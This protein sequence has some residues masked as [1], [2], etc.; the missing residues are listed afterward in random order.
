MNFSG[1][2]NELKSH[3]RVSKGVFPHVWY[4]SFYCKLTRVC[5]FSKIVY[6]SCILHFTQLMKAI[7]AGVKNKKFSHY[8]QIC[9]SSKFQGNVFKWNCL[10]CWPFANLHF[11][12]FAAAEKRT[13]LPVLCSGIWTKFSPVPTLYSLIVAT[14]LSFSFLLYNLKFDRLKWKT[15]LYV[16]TYMYINICGNAN[17]KSNGQ[18][19]LSYH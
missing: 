19:L 7:D 5:C 17:V 4:V 15:Q 11:L 2:K 16:Y 18:I 3:L 6:N 13:L 10:S 12:W 14:L 8:S 1:D 9:T